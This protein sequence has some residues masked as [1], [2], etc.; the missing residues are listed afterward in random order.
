M[1]L[2]CTTI[3]SSAPNSLLMA[4]YLSMC[5]IM[6]NGTMVIEFHFFNQKEKKKKK[7]MD[8]L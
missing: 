7:N 1:S 3:S 4:L 6:I 8:N 5:N 2:I